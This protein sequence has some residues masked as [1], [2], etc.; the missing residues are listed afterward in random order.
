VE[1]DKGLGLD[2]DFERILFNKWQ[3]L[4]LPLSVS[5]IVL[6]AVKDSSSVTS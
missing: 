4:Q 3:P 1:T 2:R 5:Y 6:T